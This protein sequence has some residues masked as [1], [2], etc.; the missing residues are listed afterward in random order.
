MCV[1]VC[2]RERER[3]RVREGERLSIFLY[4]GI[5]NQWADNTSG[6]LSQEYHR[7]SC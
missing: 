1:C 7:S 5:F 3:E 2:V 4:L 6:S